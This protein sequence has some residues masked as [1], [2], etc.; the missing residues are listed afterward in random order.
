MKRINRSDLLAGLG[1]GLL[2]LLVVAGFAQAGIALFGSLDAW[3]AALATAEPYLRVWR[4]G[5]YATLI[6][7]WLKLC[8]HHRNSPENLM[9]IR[10][11]GLQGFGT[12]AV[13]E[14]IHAGTA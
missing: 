9:R 3:N 2:F 5:L 8:R 13:L 14:F 12:C 11:I 1:I 10:R 7:A 4:A 6:C